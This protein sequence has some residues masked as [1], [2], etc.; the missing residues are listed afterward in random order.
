MWVEIS[1]FFFLII[2][3]LGGAVGVQSGSKNLT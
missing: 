1:K 2:L 3:G